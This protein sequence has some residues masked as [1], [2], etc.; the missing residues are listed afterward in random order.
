M[1][2]LYVPLCLFSMLKSPALGHLL[3]W[4][5]PS[6]L[7]RSY[8]CLKPLPLVN[9]FHPSFLLPCLFLILGSFLCDNYGD[10]H[11]T[12]FCPKDCNSL[13]LTCANCPGSTALWPCNACFHCRQ[14]AAK[15]SPSDPPSCP[16]SPVCIDIL[17]GG[18]W[19][20]LCSESPDSPSGMY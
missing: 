15:F 7:L 2:A 12:P 9:R 3:Q 4:M 20:Q 16:F 19:G 18:S 6:L 11:P 14:Q 10:T 17:T 5:Q 8:L 13:A 1:P